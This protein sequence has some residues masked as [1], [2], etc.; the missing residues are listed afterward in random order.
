[1]S[2][3]AVR[4][5]EAR[6]VLVVTGAGISAES[7]VPTFRGPG[8]LWRD[9]RPEDLATAAAFVRDPRLVWEWYEWRRQKVASVAPNPAHQALVELEG[10][11]PELLLATQNVDGLHTAAGSRRVLELHGSLWT[12]R[13]MACREERREHREALAE[14]PP[15]CRCGGLQRPGV[16]WFGEALVPDV[17]RE[18]MAA[19]NQ[20]D[21]VLV[22][23]T[24]SVVYPAAA[25]PETARARGAFVIE[26]NPEDTPLTPLAHAALRGTAVEIVPALVGGGS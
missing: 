4:L 5:R 3:A 26:V 13:C 11:A 17:L 12:L 8:G 21:V 16:V 22:V 9:F 7:G 20:A 18:A 15:R 24:S 1:L 14:L 23:G 25:L 19:A 6:R 10:R 2:D